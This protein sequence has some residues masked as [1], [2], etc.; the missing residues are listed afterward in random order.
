MAEGS[1]DQED[2]AAWPSLTC[3]ESLGMAHRGQCS[4]PPGP[5]LSPPRSPTTA[6]RSAVRHQLSQ[7]KPSRAC[8]TRGEDTGDSV[9][10]HPRV[11]QDVLTSPPSPHVPTQPLAPRQSREPDEPDT[12][13]PTSQ[14]LLRC[15]VSAQT[16]AGLYQPTPMPTKKMEW[17]R[18][19][20]DTFF[21]TQILLAYYLL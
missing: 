18:F 16:R 11:G 15:Q 4:T 19:F 12:G 1:S 9:A 14:P 5:R 10:A 3:M 6:R 17:K 20:P 2:K 21:S 7:T 8:A 13:G